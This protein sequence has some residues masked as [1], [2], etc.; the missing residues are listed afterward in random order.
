MS[1]V[2]MNEIYFAL[3]GIKVSIQAFDYS[4][5]VWISTKTNE[6]EFLIAYSNRSK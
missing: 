1:Y 6:K 4:L 2:I 3:G 5:I